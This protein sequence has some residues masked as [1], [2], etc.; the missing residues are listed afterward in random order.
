[1]N[2]V[3][4]R[5]VLLGAL[6]IGAAGALS[7]CTSAVRQARDANAAPGGAGGTLVLGSLA[8]IDPK[9]IYSQSVTTMAI[10]LLVWDT[11]IRYDR[12]TRTPRPAVA[13]SWDVAPDGRSLTL[14]L[15]DDVRFHTGRPLTSK[16]VAYAVSVYASDAAGSQLQAAA[17]AVTA[18]DTPDP[19]TAVLRFAAP[20]PNVFDLL[21]FM[22][23]V[24][25]ESAAELRAGTSFV[26]TGPFRFDGRE[27]AAS[28]DF[29]RFDGYWRGPARLDGVTL[30]VV[31]DAGALLT[32]IR[33]G[34]SDL[35]LDAAPRA[36]RQFRDQSLYR[37]TTGDVHD[38]AYYVG[39]NVAA[40]G[41]ADK[42]VRQAISYAV[43]R[44]RI[45][46]E[47]FAGAAVPSSAP[48]AA[49]SPAYDGTAAS[50]YRTDRDRARALL[51][52][53]GGPRRLTLSYPTGLAAAPAIAAIVQNDL[54]EVGITVE[55]DPR[56][57][58]AFSP[59]LKS[60]KHELWVGPHGFGQSDPLT[61]AGGAAPFKPK[62]NL[63]GF[64]APEYTALVARLGQEGPGR[65][66]VLR[67]Y[68]DYLLDQQFV[69][70]LAISP[71]T[72][73]SPARVKGL[74]WNLYKYVDL[75]GV[76]VR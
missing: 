26:G 22:L 62:G 23:L 38:A 13:R 2:G 9:S 45:A 21:E 6:G 74:D 20:V 50:H 76:T 25:S 75:H 37:I 51:A 5:S 44:D 30:R 10:G 31:R 43:D 24:D 64:A 42:R 55:L 70:D 63:S 11:L 53:A 67:E 19:R 59:F 73:V 69:I 58:A 4:R 15:R 52:E 36:L 57:Q 17:K 8:D 65:P 72:Y 28:A 56:E 34:Q 1:M 3:T 27:V 40:Q 39:A 35:V 49:S 60:G 32:S 12:S 47:V 18:V 7:G 71:A 14:H 16:D 66:E 29:R 68:T 48:W 46:A 54:A 33:A 61:L 41:L